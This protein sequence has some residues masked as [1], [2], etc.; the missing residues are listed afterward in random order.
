[1]PTDSRLMPVLR[2]AINRS[3]PAESGFTSML[4]STRP[5][6]SSELRSPDTSL[7]RSCGT[8]QTRGAA[9]QIE[10]LKCLSRIAGGLAQDCVRV[11]R[12][13]IFSAGQ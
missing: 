9:A 6:K 12:L 2:P 7:S 1:M 11:G 4:A 10:C 13:G 3:R 8:E 5:D